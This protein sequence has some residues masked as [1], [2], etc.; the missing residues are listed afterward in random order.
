MDPSQSLSQ[1]RQKAYLAYHQDGIVDML[2]GATVV[3]FGLWRITGNIV[4]TF[5]SWL[6][7]TFYYALKRTITIPRFGFVRF[8][9][10]QRKT[11][12]SLMMGLLILLMLAVGGLF[13]FAQPDRM[14]PSVL[15]FM[16]K[17]HEFVL[18]GVG[19]VSMFIFGLL[20][21]IRR[22]T[23]Y[24]IVMLLTLWVAIQLGW[25]GGPTL[26]VIGSVILLLGTVYLFRFMRRYPLQPEETGNAV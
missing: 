21:G 17:F 9:A 5:L 3:G 25:P 2:I 15:V 19:A 11:Q 18:S 26:V 23:G 4:F 22:V 16:R 12:I 20:F 7:F 13:F 1:L 8:D 6:S 24:G 10:T 14:P